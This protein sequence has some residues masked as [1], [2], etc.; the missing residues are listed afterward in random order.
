MK[1]LLVFLRDDGEATWLRLDGARVTARGA[2]AADDGEPAD[3][4]VAVVPGER[5]VVHW[6][7]MPE[8]APAQATAAAR[9]LAGDVAAAPIAGT[10]VSV[11]PRDADG[12]RCLALVDR[13]AMADWLD[14]CRAAA[15][16]PDRVLPASLLI[17]PPDTGLR[18]AEAGGVVL[19]RGSRTAFAAEPDLAALLVG[20]ERVETLDDPAFEAGFA[21]ALAD[22]PVDLRQGP[23]ARRQPWRIDWRL[24]RR[25]A[26]IG[27]A[28]LLAM[29][30]VELTLLLRHGLAADVAELRL[31]EEAR[32]L[33]PRGTAIDDPVAQVQAHLAERR[34][35]D[36]SAMTAA[37]VEALREVD[38]AELVGL[39]YGPAGLAVSVSTARG[40]DIA[41]I[42]QRLLA[43][44][45]A[46]TLG[47]VRNEAGRAVVEVTVGR[48]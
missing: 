1:R 36:F 4:V 30:A 48:R 41:T 26:L 29:L 45:Y 5:A 8:L 34:R 11:G 37:L 10:H 43:A 15:S 21:A 14:R 35:S 3:E 16:D 18:A 6:V 31:A 7:E 38:G 40:G 24:L 13:A 44:G 12:Q 32:R 42:E 9:L 28:A 33:L 47:A 25:T 46:P 20:E 17:P 23:F 19:V 22:A 2:G 27:G 39:R